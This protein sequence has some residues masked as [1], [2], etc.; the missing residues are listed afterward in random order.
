MGDSILF[1]VYF[2]IYKIMFKRLYFI[3][4]FIIIYYKIKIIAFGTAAM[5]TS[6]DSWLVYLIS[7]GC[8]VWNLVTILL[9]V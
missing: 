5:R 9:C 6:V 2:F 7:W 1:D 3:T 8:R 4:L